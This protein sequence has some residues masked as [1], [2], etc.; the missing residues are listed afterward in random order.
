L[1]SQYCRD[2]AECSRQFWIVVLSA[3]FA[4]YCAASWPD[5]S[6]NT[7]WMTSVP[8]SQVTSETTPLRS[9]GPVMVSTSSFSG[10]CAAHGTESVSAASQTTPHMG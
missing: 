9:C 5:G 4:K 7:P 3:G 6:A 8:P 10:V 1:V 2:A